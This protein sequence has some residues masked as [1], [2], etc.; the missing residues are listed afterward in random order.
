[1]A[2]ILIWTSRNTMAKQIVPIKIGV[3]LGSFCWAW[4]SVR[5]CLLVT[6]WPLS[7]CWLSWDWDLRLDPFSCSVGGEVPLM[8]PR[9]QTRSSNLLRHVTWDGMKR[10][11]KAK[12]NAT[13]WCKSSSGAQN[14]LRLYVVLLWREQSTP[15]LTDSRQI[16]GRNSPI[17]TCSRRRDS[18]WRSWDKISWNN[19]SL[20]TSL[21]N[22]SPRANKKKLKTI[23]ESN[24]RKKTYI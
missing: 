16:K 7:T 5:E 2:I 15:N 24:L 1:M 11:C 21:V 12:R 19:L 22:W 9:I 20:K 8:R 23:N 17:S 4:W 14:S 13:E 3:E 18:R 10:I 6:M